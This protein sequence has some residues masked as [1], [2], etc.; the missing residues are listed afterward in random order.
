MSACLIFIVCASHQEK[1]AMC[2]RANHDFYILRHSS[3]VKEFKNWN[4]GRGWLIG[5]YSSLKISH[6]M[7]NLFLTNNLALR[8][9]KILCFFFKQVRTVHVSNPKRLKTSVLTFTLFKIVILYLRNLKRTLDLFLYLDKSK[10][11][12]SLQLQ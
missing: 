7:F 1:C 4:L 2:A 11:D 10:L 12:I 6:V 3:W 8:K 9:Q 5:N